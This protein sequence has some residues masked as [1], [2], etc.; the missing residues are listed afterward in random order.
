VREDEKWQVWQKFFYSAVN[1]KYGP[2][3]VAWDRVGFAQK[4]EFSR[5][6]VLYWSCL[7]FCAKQIESQGNY[8]YK[9]FRS[10]L[11]TL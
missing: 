7:T 1:A 10:I 5:T 4:V 11:V 2:T 8:G 3:S 6:A 9:E